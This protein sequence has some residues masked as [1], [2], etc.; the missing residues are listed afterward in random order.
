MLLYPFVACVLGEGRMGGA[1]LGVRRD[2]FDLKPRRD[3]GGCRYGRHGGHRPAKPLGCVGESE[4]NCRVAILG[5]SLVERLFLC[6]GMN[7]DLSY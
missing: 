5:S 1:L 3:G 7:V 6:L 4:A 2:T